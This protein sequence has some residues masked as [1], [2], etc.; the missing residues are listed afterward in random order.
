MGSHFLET[1]RLPLSP[2]GLADT[3]ALQRLCTKPGERQY[4]WDGEVITRGADEG[5]RPP[6]RRAVRPGWAGLWAVLPREGGGAVRVMQK[7]GMRVDRRETIKSLDTIFY[8][9][10]RDD[11]RD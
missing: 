2:L 10:A 3:D 9:I 8:G 7:L 4:L 6:E 11:F 1:N 5:G